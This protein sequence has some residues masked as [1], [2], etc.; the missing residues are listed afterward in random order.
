MKLNP[1]PF[2]LIMSGIKTIELRLNDEKRQ[3]IHIEDEIV[4]ENTENSNGITVKVLKIYKYESFED[5][6]NELPLLKCGYT[7]EDI[8][9]ANAS[10]MDIYYSKEIQQKFGVLGIEIELL[11]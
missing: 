3:L 11:Q 5:L 8:D 2:E 4:F 10:D 6:Y 9:T 7:E 1:Q